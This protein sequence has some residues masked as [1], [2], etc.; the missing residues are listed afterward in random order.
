MTTTR[1]GGLV[2]IGEL[3]EITKQRAAQIATKAGFPE[4]VARSRAGRIWDLDAVEAWGRTWNRSNKGGR[5]PKP[6]P[7]PANP[8]GP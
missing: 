3:F 6:K 7:S 8:D 1:T 5:P 2:E 4:P